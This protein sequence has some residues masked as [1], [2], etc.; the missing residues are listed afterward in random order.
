MPNLSHV[1]IKLYLKWI[2]P[3]ASDHFSKVSIETWSNYLFKAHIP[4]Q[5][6]AF[7]Q[8]ANWKCII[9]HVVLS[10][11]LY[12]L[13]TLSSDMSLSKYIPFYS[14]FV[15]CFSYYFFSCFMSGEH[16]SLNRILPVPKIVWII[17][18]QVYLVP[19]IKLISARVVSW[20]VCASVCSYKYQNCR[21]FQ[22][23]L[24]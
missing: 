17:W 24:P 6:C 14:I 2:V 15:Y 22:R 10:V 11:S 20:I 7:W 13:S 12:R 3:N 5:C 19:W 9:N 23:H 1:L 16:C 4:R 21:H 8:S 18:Q